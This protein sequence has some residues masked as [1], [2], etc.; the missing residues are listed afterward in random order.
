MARAPTRLTLPT[1]LETVT[2]IRLE[3]LAD[4][5]LPGGGPGRAGNGNLV[6]SEFRATATSKTDPTKSMPLAFQRAVADFGQENLPVTNAID[7][8]PGTVW[9][10]YPQ[11]GKNHFGVFESRM[12]PRSTAA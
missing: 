10:I 4:P 2:A 8:N 12:T 6:L 5:K 7:G 9:A 11:V 3:L 1:D